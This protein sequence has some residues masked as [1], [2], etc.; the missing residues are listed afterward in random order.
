MVVQALIAPA[1]ITT[2]ISNARIF[3][4]VRPPRR[5]S[6]TVRPGLCLSH[7]KILVKRRRGLRE[8][9]AF[10]FSFYAYREYA[11]EVEN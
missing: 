8:G 5:R 7:Y 9:L 11:S 1:A 2:P 6:N 3:L 4:I 10:V